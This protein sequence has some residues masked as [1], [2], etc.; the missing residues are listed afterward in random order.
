MLQDI[1]DTNC[2]VLLISEKFG[3]ELFEK[4]SAE[5]LGTAN[6]F[7]ITKDNTTIY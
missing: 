5:D 6:A 3:L 2:V 1:R 4:S 7:V